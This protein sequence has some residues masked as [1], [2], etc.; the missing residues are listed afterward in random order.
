MLETESR[1]HKMRM[2]V[3]SHSL[4][5]YRFSVLPGFGPAA[6][7]LLFRQK[8]PKPLTPSLAGLHGT[9]ARGRAS[10]L[11]TLKQGPQKIK[12]VRPWGQPAGVGLEET[13][14]LEG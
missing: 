11:A 6:E 2:M 3:G 4:E 9:N 14:I 5:S 10:Q 1:L 13:N 12:S 7:V 8:D